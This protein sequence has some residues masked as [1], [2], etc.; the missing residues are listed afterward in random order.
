MH[1][2]SYLSCEADAAPDLHCK[3]SHKQADADHKDDCNQPRENHMGP[4]AHGRHPTLESH[5]CQWV[6]NVNDTK[7]DANT[8]LREAHVRHVSL[9][10]AGSSRMCRTCTCTSTSASTSTGTSQ[11]TPHKSRPTHKSA[12]PQ[13]DANSELACLHKSIRQTYPPAR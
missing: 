7:K 4:T 3:H 2:R 11:Y 5:A 10:S 8:Q 13:A 9:A 6:T 1:N 12:I